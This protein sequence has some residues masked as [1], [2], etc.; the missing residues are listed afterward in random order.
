MRH[1]CNRSRRSAPVGTLSAAAVCVFLLASPLLA[2]TPTRAEEIAKQQEA[3]AA[4]AAPDVPSR[5]ERFF[6]QFEKGK[7]FVGA[8]RGWYPAFG[9]IYDGGGIAG[10]AGYRRYIGYDS[11]VDASAMYSIANYKQFKLT[12]STPNHARNRLDL[13]GTISWVDATQVPFFGLGN[14]SDADNRTNFAIQRT[15][16]AG[17]A[18]LHLVDWLRLKVDGGLDDYRQKLGRGA[19]PSIEIL[20]TPDTAPLLGQHLRYLRGE[21]SAA[22][23]WMPTPAYS[24]RGGMARLAYEE[25]SPQQGGGD[26]FG[27]ARAEVV[28]HI[29]VLRETWVLSLRGRS[30]SVVRPSD[31]VPYFLMPW[32]GSGNT[33]RGYTTGRFRDRHSLLLTGELRWFPNRLGFDMALFYDA[34]KVAPERAGLTLKN[35]KTDVGVGARFHT[36]A[37]TALRIDLAH[38]LEGFRLVFTGSA[39]F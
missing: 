36:P 27:I 11:Y 22:A 8:P 24:R 25:F 4:T 17:V 35:M 7:W 38:G 26:T 15:Q 19:F 34:G 31:E 33:L 16:V 14:D 18:D 10:G 39:P 29:P 30:E 13:S 9:S 37:A 3:R 2:Q 12:G 21:V 28:Q 6:E 32:L 1:V 5:A 20:F 23:L